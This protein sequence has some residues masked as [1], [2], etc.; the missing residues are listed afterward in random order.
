LASMASGLC[1]TASTS[2]RRY[3][4]AFLQQGVDHFP[5]PAKFG[6]NFV[7]GHHLLSC[8]HDRSPTCSLSYGPIRNRITCPVHDQGTDLVARVVGQIMEAAQVPGLRQA[9][10]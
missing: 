9:L 2:S 8:A 3:L 4:P 5:A 7:A 6:L 1:A 10:P